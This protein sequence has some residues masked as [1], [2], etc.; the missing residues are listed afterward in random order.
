M[1]IYVFTADQAFDGD[2]FDLIVKA[3]TKK[4]DAIAE[5]KLFVEDVKKDV[6]ER[7]M[8]VEVNEDDVYRA[9]VPMDYANQHVELMITETELIK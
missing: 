2:C 4:E 5:L 8:E 9:C 6:D 1:K 3:Y 7:G